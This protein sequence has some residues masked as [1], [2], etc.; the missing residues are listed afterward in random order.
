MDALMGKWA[1][2]VFS[3]MGTAASPNLRAHA[4]KSPNLVFYATE[5]HAFKSPNVTFFI[6]C[7]GH[8]SDDA[9]RWSSL[10]PYCIVQ[11]SYICVTISGTMFH[12]DTRILCLEVSKVPWN[13]I[14]IICHVLLEIC[15]PDIRISK[16][17]AGY[18]RSIK[19]ISRENLPKCTINPKQP[20]VFG[21]KFSAREIGRII[22]H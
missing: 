6:Y 17:S 3:R 14:D 8:I 22:F 2:V 7:W 21:V 12:N 4:L 10:W 16:I 11:I 15:T 13:G 18:Q 20:K 9:A 5:T 19:R 1:L